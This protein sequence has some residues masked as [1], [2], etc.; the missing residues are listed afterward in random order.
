MN[1]LLLLLGIHGINEIAAHLIL[2]MVS[3]K[4]M[5]LKRAPRRPPGI[6]KKNE[7]NKIERQIEGGAR[8]IL[9]RVSVAAV[10]IWTK[11]CLVKCFA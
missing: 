10:I 6:K 8:V 9:P 11:N 2:N 1:V 5:W 3:L 7:F 4:L